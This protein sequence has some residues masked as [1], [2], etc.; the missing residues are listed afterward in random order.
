MAPILD[1]LSARGRLRQPSDWARRDQP[2]QDRRISEEPYIPAAPLAA[3][4]GQLYF[5]VRSFAADG[6]GHTLQFGFVDHEANVVLSAFATSPSPVGLFDDDGP[7]EPGA[8]PMDHA[9][10]ERLLVP[11]CH[12]ATLVGFHRV[13]Q[14]GLLPYPALRAVRG[15]RCAWRRMQDAAVAHNLCARRDRPMTLNEALVL[16]DFPPLETDDAVSR[17]L[18]I[19]QIWLW[20]DALD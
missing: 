14:C 10:L 8:E 19:R 16:A 15:F 2:P 1:F 11:L 5:S 18:A 3:P 6:R 12:G 17:A 20:L 4:A 9:A 7:V 13:L